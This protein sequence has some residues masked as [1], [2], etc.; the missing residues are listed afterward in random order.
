M[1]F[2]LDTTCISQGGR[3]RGKEQG[4]SKLRE[5]MW[6]VER[7]RKRVNFQIIR[8][9]F[10]TIVP[11]SLIIFLA[12]VALINTPP[13][14]PVDASSIFSFMSDH[15]D[16]EDV[17]NCSSG[18][19]FRW[20]DLS[21][22]SSIRDHGEGRAGTAHAPKGGNCNSKVLLHPSSGFVENGHICGIIGPSGAGKSTL[23]SALGGTALKSSRVQVSGA[24]W[25]DEESDSPGEP[26]TKS[27]PS[28]RDGEVAVLHQNDYFFSMLTVR[29][30]VELAAFLQLGGDGADRRRVVDGILDS[31]GL[32][33][34]ENRRIGFLSGGER[35]RLSFALEVVTAPKLFLGDEPT[36]GLDSSQ[37]EKVVHLMAKLAREKNIPCICSL[38]QPR[39]SI[40]KTLDSFILLAPGGRMIYIGPR[41]DATSYFEKLGYK[42]PSETNPAEYFI[43]LVSVDNE[44]PKQAEV[45]RKRI[46]HLSEAY[47][48]H[49][50]N[51]V[52]PK[53]ELDSEWS[54]PTDD[55]MRKKVEHG[56][57]KKGFV[58]RLRVL[59]LR[60][61]RQNIRNNKV[62]LIRLVGSIGQSL[63]FSQ[64]FKTV[65][66]GKPIA[67]SIAD[68]TALLS[69][70]VINMSM[71]AL[72]KTL[73]LFGKEKAVVARERLR[74]QYSAF[75]YLLCKILAEIPLDTSFAAVFAVVLK[76]TT[77]LRIPL[78]HLAGTFSL[79]TI[80][81]ASLG[82][83]VGG[84]TPN[85]EAAITTGVP[86]M[87]I[88]MVVGII[89]PG[90]VDLSDPPPKIIQLL[91]LVSPVK[92][93]VE[94]LCVA[95]FRGM[96]FGQGGRRWRLSDLPRMGALAMVKNGDQVLDALGLADATY[97]D[98]MKNLAILSAVNFFISWL[99]L[100]CGG[101]DIAEASEIPSAD[102]A[103]NHVEESIHLADDRLSQDASREMKT[104]IVRKIK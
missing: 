69:F 38:H 28:I 67:R 77:G 17:G 90:G 72:M 27:H 33:A 101:S 46:K 44:D 34:V 36:T 30:T 6:N 24:V 66:H 20:K 22:S 12:A 75:E 9:G 53:H 88:L 41:K 35:R 54:P 50:K 78:L 40:W 47:T 16:N 89:N 43:D 96:E 65:Q 104:P 37:A 61:F 79:M 4:C 100:H 13:F 39:A 21:V 59:F 19:G 58:A 103:A 62:N 15:K 48:S 80:A 42:C 23:L 85:A 102:D 93:S 51:H 91:K 45:D 56:A 32:S 68:R 25:L 26:V 87:V 11:S 64:I 1:T 10:A 3:L 76:S 49:I 82:F 31:L 99:G 73:E 74:R 83:A 86:I 71:M 84:F 95:E 70:G 8:H 81:G 5:S 63:L 29:E 60:S 97:I 94:A 14:D 57:R 7:P 2:V 18:G 92:H 55:G 98:L 52:K